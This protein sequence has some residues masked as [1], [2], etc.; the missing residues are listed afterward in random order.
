MVEKAEGEMAAEGRV[1]AREEAGMEAGTVVV[2]AVATAEATVAVAAAAR[3]VVTAAQKAAM[4]AARE[5]RM[6]Q[7]HSRDT[8][9]GRYP[10]RWSSRRRNRA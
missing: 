9:P 1:V 6:G 7:L 2:S 10:P 5:E 4:A 3:A 8:R